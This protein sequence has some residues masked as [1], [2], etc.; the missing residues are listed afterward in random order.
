VFAAV[1]MSASAL[2]WT[3]PAWGDDPAAPP[4]PGPEFDVLRHMVGNWDATVKAGP[5]EGKCVASYRL[6]CGGLWLV[7]NFQGT[8]GSHP[9]QGKGMDSYD[10]TKKKYVSV[11]VDSMIT[12]P[13]VME[14]AYDAEKKTLTMSTE[15]PDAD[16]KKSKMVSEM[17]DPNTMVATMHSID[18]DGKEIE[19]MTITYKRSAH[20]ELRRGK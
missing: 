20:V 6:E 18:K 12:S 7:S 2:A 16:G 15:S 3:T 11:W 5:M 1:V 8:F 17:K 4:K 19:V 9:F 14:G 10:A 13:M